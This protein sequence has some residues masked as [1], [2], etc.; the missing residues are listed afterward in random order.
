M[1][2][3]KVNIVQRHKRELCIQDIPLSSHNTENTGNMYYNNIYYITVNALGF[4]QIQQPFTGS[5]GEYILT[6]LCFPLK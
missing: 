1:E 5:L 6:S 4:R 3:R 2:E